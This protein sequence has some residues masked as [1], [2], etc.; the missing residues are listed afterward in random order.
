MMI[1][2]EAA[3]GPPDRSRQGWMIPGAHGV[4]YQRI[5]MYLCMQRCS[6]FCDCGILYVK[7]LEHLNM[8]K[9]FAMQCKCLRSSQL[10]WATPRH[11]LWQG[12]CFALQHSA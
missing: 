9:L 12:H 1:M 2:S 6:T 3:G 11:S 5:D 8:G 4:W 7:E 10:L